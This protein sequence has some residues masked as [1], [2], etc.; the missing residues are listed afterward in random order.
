MLL[1]FNGVIT[2]FQEVKQSSFGSM[3]VICS[4][5]HSIQ[6]SSEVC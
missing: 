2:K 3:A 5:I 4:R 6:Q 1:L